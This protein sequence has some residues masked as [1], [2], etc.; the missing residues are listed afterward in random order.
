MNRPNS[1]YCAHKTFSR[2]GNE[3]QRSAR[4][5]FTLMELMLVLALLVILGAMAYPALKGPFELQTMRK[6]GELVRVELCKARLKA[7]KTGQVQMFTFEPNTGN[8]SIQLYYTEQ[9]LL[10]ADA[11][12]SGLGA[13]GFGVG[14]S[15]SRT[16]TVSQTHELPEHIVFASVEV[17]GDTR[18]MQLQQQAQG[19]GGTAGFG[20]AGTGLAQGLSP[21]LFYPDGTASNAKVILT[22][23]TQ[24]AYVVVSL[25]GLTGVVKVS[26]LV[27]AD[28]IQ[29]IP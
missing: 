23:E 4:S 19:G 26:G 22:N 17:Q 15:G 3:P 21:I 13:S 12:M 20:A 6:A 16:A 27:S 25:R 2:C 7:M 9:G 14:G 8:Y 28:E 10:E 1:R 24:K 18:S 5:A 11:T 29:Q